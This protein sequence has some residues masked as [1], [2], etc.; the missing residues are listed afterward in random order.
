[1][2]PSQRKRRRK[3]HPLRAPRDRYGV[4]TY[5]RAIAY[6]CGRSG[7]PAWHPNQLR[8]NAMTEIRARFGLEAAQAV[9]GHTKPQTTTIYAERDIER[10]RT[11]MREI[12]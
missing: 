5:R 12:V 8:H 7:V 1:M 6:A 9:L 3:K 10:A 2:T 11:T 4:A